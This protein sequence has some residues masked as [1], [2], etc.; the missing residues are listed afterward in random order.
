[1]H[2]LF[3]FGPNGSYFLS[4]ETYFVFSKA[5]LPGPVNDLVEELDRWTLSEP[6]APPLLRVPW[7]VAFPMEEG[8]YTM[9][10]T[11]SEP[12]CFMDVNLGPNYTRLECF[13]NK[14]AAARV[15]TSCTVFGPQYSYFSM[16]PAGYSWQ[17]LS[18]ELEDDIQNGLLKRRP[19][20][21]A[22]GIQGSHVV[23]YDDGSAGVELHGQYPLVEALLQNK[24]SRQVMHLAL[25]P[26]VAGQYYAVLADGSTSWD[27]PTAWE[28]Q[29]TGMDPAFANLNQPEP[30]KEVSA[31]GTGTV[32]HEV[33]SAE[34]AKEG[35]DFE[36][37]V[38]V[39]EGVKTVVEIYNAASGSG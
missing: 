38:T 18:P 11:K 10:W 9:S 5:L 20:V 2:Y 12:G 7:D 39:L 29:V 17:N 8:L 37:G 35:K 25:N 36:M 23:L 19:V 32:Q 13:I 4:A 3:A 26:F 21:V 31:G 28:E 6:N 27:L 24:G 22:L 15:Y 30:T 34:P 33:I 14:A 16:S 1:M